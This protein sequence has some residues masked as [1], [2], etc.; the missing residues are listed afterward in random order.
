M[1]QACSVGTYCSTTAM[2]Q[3]TPCPLGQYCAQQ[4]TTSPTK[5]LA[6]KYQNT[7]GATSVSAC[8]ACPAGNYCPTAATVNPTP[9]PAG[10]YI[11]VQGATDPTAAT[12][13]GV[14]CPLCGEGSTAAVL[15]CPPGYFCPDGQTPQQCPVGTYKA[16]S[17]SPLKTAADCTA[18]DTQKYCGQAGMTAYG[19]CPPGTYW[20]SQNTCSACQPG[21][22]CDVS[23]WASPQKCAAGSINSGLGAKS[24]VSTRA[25][26]YSRFVGCRC[27]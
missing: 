5:C 27:N 25:C 20:T 11:A 23:L 9:S 6:G 17:G 18:C 24:Q 13:Q 3:A 4:S 12:G 16:S 21:Y 26:M 10:F 22:Y 1:C 8:I 7:T 19:L 15:A 14:V 2:T